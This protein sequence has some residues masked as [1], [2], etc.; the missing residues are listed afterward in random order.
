MDQEESSMVMDPNENN[1]APDTVENREKFNNSLQQYWKQKNITFIKQPTIGGKDL[2]FYVLYSSVCQRG[3]AIKVSDNKLWREIVNELKLPSSC[4]SAS[5]TLKNHYAKYLLG[6]EIIHMHKKDDQDIPTLAPG[7]NFKNENIKEGESG[8]AKNNNSQQNDNNDK[9]VNQQ[10]KKGL[11][12]QKSESKANLM[13]SDDSVSEPDEINN[14]QQSSKKLINT[15]KGNSLENSFEKEQYKK[16]G[17]EEE[18]FY[19]N[20]MKLFPTQGDLKRI[21]LAFQS[22]ISDDIVYAINQLLFYSVNMQ[23][24][25]QLNK[26]PNLLD[27]I[28]DYLYNILQRLPDFNVNK[29]DGNNYVYETYQNLDDYPIGTVLLFNQ[30]NNTEISPI[31]LLQKNVKSKQKQKFELETGKVFLDQ[32]RTIFLILRNL[33]YQQVNEKE[34]QDNDKLTELMF[35]LFCEN[36][37]QEISNYILEIIASLAKLIKFKL[38]PKQKQFTKQLYDYLNSEEH[39]LLESTVDILRQCIPTH[40]NQIVFEKEIDQYLHQIVNLLSIGNVDI[41]EGLL[42]FLCYLTDQSIET[43]VKIAS[44]PRFMER[45]ITILGS[46][47]GKQNERLTKLGA[48]VLNNLSFSNKSRQYILPFEEDILLVA[49]TDESVSRIL[50]DILNE[51]DNYSNI[52]AVR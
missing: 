28:S 6:F 18:V 42:E 49:S 39:D 14:I 29:E 20:E 3:G 38:I 48:L 11:S 17:E 7:R 31:S 21:V 30:K 40:E 26:V 25:F 24:P 43:K 32:A 27:S 45:L 44:Y 36:K 41:K 12:I 19:Y 52:D 37:D 10:L 35:N 23:D 8:Q 5:F 46:G 4:T 50:S 34:I 16:F 22:R 51:M 33:S 1:F 15:N 13:D 9:P 47:L 2:D